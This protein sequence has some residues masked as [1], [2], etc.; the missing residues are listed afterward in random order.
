MISS[1]AERE[2]DAQALS[3]TAEVCLAT[4][5][6]PLKAQFL[7]GKKRFVAEG[8]SVLQTEFWLMNYCYSCND[9]LEDVDK[10]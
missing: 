2:A 8:C 6:C 4:S 10:S 9:L 5:T 1:V 3:D 7:S